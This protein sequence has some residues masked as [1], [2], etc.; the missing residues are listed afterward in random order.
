MKKPK[1]REV[2]FAFA[3]GFEDS[4]HKFVADGSIEHDRYKIF[5]E[6]KGNIPPERLPGTMRDHN[7][8]PPLEDFRECHFSG[9][10]LLLYTHENDVVMLY[11]VCDHG[12]IKGKRGSQLAKDLKK[13]KR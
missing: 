7:L 5:L 12:A 13:R 9:D 6:R 1:K 2:T 10:V 4:L 11:R 8:E 3:E